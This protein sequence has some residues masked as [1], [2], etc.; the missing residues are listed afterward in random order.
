MKY[1]VL[2]KIEKQMEGSSLNYKE[3]HRQ[4]HQHLI[5]LLQPIKIN[6]INIISSL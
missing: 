6:H 3:K 2:H 1:T 4:A 5:L